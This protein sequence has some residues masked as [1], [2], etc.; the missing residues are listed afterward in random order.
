MNPTQL[1]IKYAKSKQPAGQLPRH[2]CHGVH[3]DQTHEEWLES[4]KEKNAH[5]AKVPHGHGM[6]GKPGWLPKDW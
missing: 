2:D 1:A 4:L 3:P 5:S 6:A